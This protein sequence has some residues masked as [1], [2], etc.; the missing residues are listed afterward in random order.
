MYAYQ[1]RSAVVDL[2]DRQGNMLARCANFVETVEIECSRRR[3]QL[4]GCDEIDT[5]GPFVGFL[6]LAGAAF[7]RYQH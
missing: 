4:A 5:H 1:Y 7:N 6:G 3:L 2:S